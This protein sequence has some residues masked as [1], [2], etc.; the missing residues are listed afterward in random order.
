L[1][2]SVSQPRNKA[3]LPPLG[4]SGLKTFL[5]LLGYARPH[6]AMFLLGVLGMVLYGIVV[7]AEIILMPWA[8]DSTQKH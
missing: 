4:A 6:W 2:Q 5:R 8:V 3:P 7:L 1:R